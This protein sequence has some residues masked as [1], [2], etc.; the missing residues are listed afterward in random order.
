MKSLIFISIFSVVLGFAGSDDN[1][2]P[3]ATAKH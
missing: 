3:T 2:I 1:K